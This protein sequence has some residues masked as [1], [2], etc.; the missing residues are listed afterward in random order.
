[1]SSA[2][3]TGHL[4]LATL[5]PCLQCDGTEVA[6]C[7]TFNGANK[8]ICDVCQEDYFL[9]E[10]K[11]SCGLCKDVDNCATMNADSCQGCD[12]C[13]EGYEKSLDKK[14]CTEASKAGQGNAYG[15]ASQY[16][17]LLAAQAC[18]AVGLD[19]GLQPGGRQPPLTSD[20]ILRTSPAPAV[21]GGQLRNLHPRHLHLHSLRRWV[22]AGRRQLCGGKS[23]CRVGW[24]AGH[25][26]RVRLCGSKRALLAMSACA[27]E[28]MCVPPVTEGW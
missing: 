19:A 28:P 9:S 5:P 8:C 17:A 21:Q 22:Q 4:P 12:V 20:A 18:N 10:D 2:L 1:M 24:S 7:K 14:T 13:K 23:S 27:R 25:G 16:A 26:R 15:R 3:L 6:N 11:K